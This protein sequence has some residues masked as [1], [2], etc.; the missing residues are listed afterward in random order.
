MY[1]DKSDNAQQWSVHA[2]VTI[3]HNP[4]NN[5]P[6]VVPPPGVTHTEQNGNGLRMVYTWTSHPPAAEDFSN[7]NLRPTGG[8]A[9]PPPSSSIFP[10]SDTA[11]RTSNQSNQSS[12]FQRGGLVFTSVPPGS[13]ASQQNTNPFLEPGRL[14]LSVHDS[15]Y[16]SEL[17]SP[18]SCGASLPRRTILPYDRRCR[19]TCSII[20]STAFNADGHI[21]CDTSS[22]NTQPVSYHQCGRT[23]SLRCQTPSVKPDR[24]DSYFGCGDPWCYHAEDFSNRRCSPVLESCEECN[25]SNQSIGSKRA[26]RANT[27]TTHFCTKVP[28][29]NRSSPPSFDYRSKDMAVQTVETKDKCTSPFEKI[30]PLNKLVSED[31]S[32]TNGRRKTTKKLSD[33]RK[34]S[35]T[36]S[37]RSSDTLS[38]SSLP[39]DS[40]DNKKV[41]AFLLSV[42]ELSV[43]VVFSKNFKV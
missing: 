19:S 13:S 33:R 10:V 21:K 35:A 15:G 27:F 30:T 34:S 23:Q 41:I 25:L 17:L 4:P 24:R 32:V 29:R 5:E 28:E 12:M 6:T 39:I 11:S 42:K 16:N 20:L 22:V 36:N 43:F 38:P 3:S 2:E 37:R 31:K 14:N 7:P 40:A 8:P 1:S 18:S 26:S 9:V